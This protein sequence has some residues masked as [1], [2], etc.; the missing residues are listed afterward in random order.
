MTPSADRSE[1]EHYLSMAA[2]YDACIPAILPMSDFFFSSALSFIPDTAETLLELGSGT[3]YATSRI[4]ARHPGIKIYGIDHSPQ[5]I[6]YALEKPE[7]SGILF[8]EQDIM[9]P[10]PDSPYNVIITTL[11]LHHIPANDRMY[12]LHRVYESLSPGGVFICGDIIRPGSD[13]AEEVYRTRWI[14][15]MEDS[16]ISR[17]EIETIVAS[18]KLNF[19]EMETTESFP[20]KMNEAGFSLALM[21]YRHEISAVFI[22]M[23]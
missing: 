14:R 8:Y 4:L 19:K 17:H 23:R 5:M 1:H 15:S 7:L 2:S 9:D 18:R 20:K 11:C 21:P 16:G 6:Q 12:L 13:P 3:G 10:W 22:G